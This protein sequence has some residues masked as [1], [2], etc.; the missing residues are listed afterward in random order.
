MANIMPCLSRR[1]SPGD[2]WRVVQDVAEPRNTWFRGP[3]DLGSSG[4]KLLLSQL[5]LLLAQDVK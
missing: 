1:H 3:V 4:Q 2:I 5:F